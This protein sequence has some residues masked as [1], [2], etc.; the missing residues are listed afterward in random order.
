MFL[1]PV[2]PSK[3]ATGAGFSDENQMPKRGAPSNATPGVEEHPQKTRGRHPFKEHP[4]KTR[5]AGFFTRCPCF[6]EARAGGGTG[7]EGRTLT[8]R[9]QL[10][11]SRLLVHVASIV[12][13]HP[14]NRASMLDPSRFKTG[15]STAGFS[16]FNPRTPALTG[17][18]TSKE[19][20]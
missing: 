7:S 13:V 8:K 3:V 19:I 17:T 18:T 15:G 12:C 4:H 2:Y 6:G 10:R 1:R 16:F 5:H 11:T 9:L 14:K 20:K